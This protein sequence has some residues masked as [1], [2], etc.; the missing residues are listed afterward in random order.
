[1]MAPRVEFVDAEVMRVTIRSRRGPDDAVRSRPAVLGGYARSAWLRCACACRRLC[2]LDPPVVA[3]SKRGC[4]LPR[5]AGF[6]T[7][8]RPRADTGR[9]P[10]GRHVR[11][12]RQAQ[13]LEAR[14]ADTGQ[15]K[16]DKALR[17]RRRRPQQWPEAGLD[18]Q[19][20]RP[21]RLPRGA[22]VR[23][24][25]HRPSELCEDAG[26]RVGRAAH[27]RGAHSPRAARLP[28]TL[29]AVPILRLR[30]RTVIVSDDGAPSPQGKKEAVDEQPGVR[31]CGLDARAAAP[32]QSP[33]ARARA[34]KR[35]A[36]SA[37][38]GADASAKAS[39]SGSSTG[40]SLRP[41]A[42]KRC[43]AACSRARAVRRQLAS[44]TARGAAAASLGVASAESPCEPAE[45]DEVGGTS[46]QRNAPAV[47]CRRAAQRCTFSRARCRSLLP[48]S[49]G[50]FARGLV[51][52]GLA[53]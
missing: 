47:R 2:A 36:S 31:P 6:V 34:G 24:A 42:H 19:D 4:H 30:R 35:Q 37:S 43:H 41:P 9:I 27:G 11:T 39:P 28:S 23:M 1:M 16:Q 38:C 33:P 25:R 18:V 14:R 51:R 21:W 48:P 26:R 17:D 50:A 15:R 53:R 10:M 22:A 49:S 20:L 29:A 32:S 7:P 5:R 13:F 3:C 8:A 12:H 46:E 52:R 40:A 45:G 44:L